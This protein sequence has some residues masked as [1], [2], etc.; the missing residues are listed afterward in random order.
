MNATLVV[1]VA[2]AVSLGTNVL[3]LKKWSDAKAETAAA[4][5]ALSTAMAAATTC[6]RAVQALQDA[7][8][9]QAEESK[10]AIEAAQRFAG[11]QT[12]AAERERQ[13]AQAVPGNACASLEVETRDWL[14]RRREGNGH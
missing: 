1:G 7:A 4:R 5:E 3:L 6:D 8:K 11:Q 10:A 2:L 13:R 14:K 9:R 12:A